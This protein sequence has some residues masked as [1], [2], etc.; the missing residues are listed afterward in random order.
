MEK[1][2]GIGRFFLA[3]IVILVIVQTWIVITQNRYLVEHLDKIASKKVIIKGDKILDEDGR[4][5]GVIE[6]GTPSEQV[7]EEKEKEAPVAAP[8]VER[9]EVEQSHID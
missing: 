3:A 2:S 7:E 5:I 9:E 6:A 4:Q 8:A 1:K